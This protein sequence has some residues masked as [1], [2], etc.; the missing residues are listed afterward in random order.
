MTEARRIRTLSLL[1]LFACTGEAIGPPPPPAVL[2]L[3][4]SPLGRRASVPSGSIAIAPDSAQVT[5]Q[6]TGASAATWSVTHSG[7]ATWVTLTSASGTGSGKLR[8]TRDPAG[9]SDGSYIDTLTVTAPGAAGSPATLFDTLE[10]TAQ[11]LALAVVPA[12]RSTSVSAGGTV[13]IADS[14]AVTLTGAGS[15][16]TTWAAAHSAQAG[17]LS[18]TT[19]AGTGSGMLRWSRD[20]TGLSAG[21]YVDTLTVTA[22][23]AAGSPARVIDTL[24]ITQAPPPAPSL[25]LVASGLSTPLFLTAPPGDAARLFIVEKTGRIRI[26]KNGGLL[27]T[28]FL[29][30][31][32]RV[33]NGSEQGLLGLAFH[34]L[35]AQNGTF[36]VNYTNPSGDTR[37]SR[38]TVSANPDLA[39]GGSEQVIL[40]VAQP[41]TNHNGGMVDFG[42]DG[43]L[44]IAL[45]DGGSGGDPLGNGQ[46]R[47]TLLGSI[48]RLDIDGAAPYVIP[49]TNP[50]ASSP[51]FKREIWAYGVRNPWRFS[52]DRTTGDLYIGEVG[53][54]AR[55]EIDFQPASST[56]G[57][58]YGWNI[59]EGT[60]CFSPSSGCNQTGLTLPVLD[61]DHSQGCSVTGGYVYRGTAVPALQGRYLYA[62]WC[63]GWV[64]SFRMQGGQAVERMDWPTLAPGGS[65]TSF[66]QDA[67]GEVYVLVGQGS[68]YR[69]VP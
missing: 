47:T 38:F 9:L 1:L 33:S 52:F 44:Y 20:P 64:R 56:G 61:Y 22:G 2:T 62:D 67:Q 55:E 13:P 43:Y 51:T 57:E 30:L 15:T 11:P 60:I 54:G 16:S 65:I 12:S 34:P 8:W 17:W 25:A 66:G 10:V 37:V 49:P 48:L 68:V 39:N 14:A 63:Q 36:V 53:Q 26:V 18:I 28:P 4:V 42:P 7:Q 50:F 6:G 58:N 69:I 40:A 29:D 27:S 46:D 59:M 35:Y 19:V 5:L 45:G 31:S 23:G 32:S 41:F 3:A 24:T 21:T